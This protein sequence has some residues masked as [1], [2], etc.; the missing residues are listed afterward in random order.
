MGLAWWLHPGR[1][2]TARM[3]PDHYIPSSPD[4]ACRQE[5]PQTGEC[6]LVE[7]KIRFSHQAP[8][9]VDVELAVKVP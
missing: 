7:R 6:L 4:R 8:P 2:E 3:Q 9:T 1:H 5:S